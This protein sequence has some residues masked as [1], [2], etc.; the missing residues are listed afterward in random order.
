MTFQHRCGR[1]P[2]GAPSSARLAERARESSPGPL[3]SRPSVSVGTTF[4]AEDTFVFVFEVRHRSAGQHAHHDPPAHA[5]C[6]CGHSFG[7]AGSRSSG[8]LLGAGSG[9]QT[10]KRSGLLILGPRPSSTPPIASTWAAA[11]ERYVNASSSAPGDREHVRV[12]PESHRPRRVVGIVSTRSPG[13]C[14][15]AP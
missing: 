10:A 5:F 13:S 8:V 4:P 1:A 9:P 12:D 11:R 7:N 2:G 3:Y 15:P 6:V 14:A